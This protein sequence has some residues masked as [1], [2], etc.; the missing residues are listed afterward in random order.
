MSASLF[1]QAGLTSSEQETLVHNA[2]HKINQLASDAANRMDPVMT[3]GNMSDY[4]FLA[5]S[6]RN[7]ANLGDE[8]EI[9][10]AHKTLSQDLANQP[11]PVLVK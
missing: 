7:F 11:T 10:C 1:T 9:A 6:A 8:L 4:M 5:T 2:I 3:A